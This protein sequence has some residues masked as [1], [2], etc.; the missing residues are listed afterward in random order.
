MLKSED[1][2]VLKKLPFD[3]LAEGDLK[4][5][6]RTIGVGV[7]NCFFEIRPNSLKVNHFLS[8]ESLEALITPKFD[9]LRSH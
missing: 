9:I 2:L 4:F 8:H 6:Q 5:L 7:H 1:K 3:I